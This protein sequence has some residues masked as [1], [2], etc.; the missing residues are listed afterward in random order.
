LAPASAK[1]PPVGDLRPT[2]SLLNS[3]L[4]GLLRLENRL[5]LAGWDFPWGISA[6]VMARKPSTA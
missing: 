6:M 2:P 4:I 3:L 5:V 1:T